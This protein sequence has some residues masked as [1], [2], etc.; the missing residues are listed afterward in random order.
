VNRLCLVVALLAFW[1]GELLAQ[2]Y[3]PADLAAAFGQAVIVIEANEHAC[4]KFDVFI[5]Q[6]DT[7]QRRGL[8]FV[9]ELPQQSGMIFV[10][11][12]AGMHSMWMKNTYIPLDIAFIRRDGRIS[13]IAK[14]TEPLSLRSIRST[15][16]VNFVLELNAGVSDRLF[17]GPES[18]VVLD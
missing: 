3:G 8:M 13:S 11:A 12:D 16:P 18:L 14:N 17:M 6:S 7:Q 15:E 9:R 2:E 4:Y 5:A 10:Y 1:P